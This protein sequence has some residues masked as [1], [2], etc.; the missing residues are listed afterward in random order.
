MDLMLQ[1]SHIIVS[2]MNYLLDRGIGCLSIHDCLIVP[3]ENLEDAKNAFYTAYEEKNY[4]RPKLSI[5]Y[6]EDSSPLV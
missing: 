6:G 1:E 4:T 2:S 3:Q 5:E